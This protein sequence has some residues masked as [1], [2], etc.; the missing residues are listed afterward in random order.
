MIVDRFTKFSLS[1]LVFSLCLNALNPWLS[2]T[3]ANA[4]IEDTEVKNAMKIIAQG[5]DRIASV[6]ERQEQRSIRLEQR[7][8][9]RYQKQ[10]QRTIKREQRIIRNEQRKL[11]QRAQGV[12]AAQQ[13]RLQDTNN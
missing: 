13:L 7:D 2:P 11:M 4:E 6:Y 5:I 1:I 3:L 9:I 12:R 8:L 10:E